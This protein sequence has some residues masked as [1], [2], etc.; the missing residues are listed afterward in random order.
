VK[1]GTARLSVPFAAFLAGIWSKANTFDADGGLVSDFPAGIC[2]WVHIVAVP[3][4]VANKTKLVRF[5][6]LVSLRACVQD[7][8][9]G[10]SSTRR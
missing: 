8:Y 1:L 4:T 9:T 2:A 10:M 7:P 6:I 5:V 3:N